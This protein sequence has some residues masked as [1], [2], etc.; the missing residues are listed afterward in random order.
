MLTRDGSSQCETR[1]LIAM[2]KEV[3]N[4]HKIPKVKGVN[5]QLRKRLV[6]SLVGWLGH[7]FRHN[8]LLKTI[9][10]GR[11]QGKRGR[12]RKG[13]LDNIKARKSYA[14]L[15]RAAFDRPG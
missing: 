10:E 9:I 4:I 12:L 3:F 11:L 6:K 2:A 7:V 8:S 13:I 15:K 1:T 5:R 14:S